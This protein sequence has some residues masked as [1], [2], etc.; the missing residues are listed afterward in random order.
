MPGHK[1]NP[2]FGIS[3]SEIDITEI[4]GYDDLHR[5]TGAILDL[6]R[7]LAQ[8]YHAERSHILVNGSTVGILAAVFAV[9]KRGDDVIIAR[10]CHKSVYNACFLRELKVS[11]AEP[12]FDGLNGYY[13]RITQSGI[14]RAVAENPN[15]KAIIITSPTYE[16]MASEI[17]SDIPVIVDAAHGAHLPFCGSCPYPKGDIVISSLHK[18]LPA[19]AQTA[20]INIYNEYYSDKISE[21][22]DVFETSSPSYVLM[23]SVSKCIE[24]IK[25]GD[26]AFARYEKNLT[27]FYKTPLNRLAFTDNDDRGKIVV[28][29]AKSNITGVALADILRNEFLIESEMASL[30]YIV[31]MTSPADTAEAFKKLSRALIAIDG[32]L[33]GKEPLIIKA[34]VIPEKRYE[35]YEITETEKTPLSD[36]VGK[37]C[38]EFVYAYPPGIP[39]IAPGEVIT[40]DA[41]NS[42]VNAERAGINILSKADLLPRFILTKSI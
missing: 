30:N 36:C 18:T 37:V 8:L 12:E 10:N 23:N 19:L 15:A 29:T 6:E 32:R 26:E 1:R 28:S 35:L 38:G 22:L 31:L 11:Y 5:P 2:H 13:T 27:E 25:N 24:F 3:G 41:V 17:T 4:N 20:V 39:V 14:D 34:P 21:Y 16:G 40:A 7:E 42:I 33:E 9:T